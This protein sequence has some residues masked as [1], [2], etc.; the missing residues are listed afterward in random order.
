MQHGDLATWYRPQMVVV[1]EGVLCD[2]DPVTETRGRIRKHDVIVGYDLSWH[3]IPLKRMIYLA[4]RWEDA[5]I[6]I[7][8]FTSPAVAERGMDYLDKANV[9]Y[10]S[11]EYHNFDEWT[12]LL[13]YQPEVVTI[14]DSDF[15]RVQRYG[16]KGTIVHRGEDF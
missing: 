9:P 6:V 13:K 14:Y 10:R 7:V 4:H 2:V 15:E 3:E 12:G 16:Q 5:D 1:M 11:L 8:T